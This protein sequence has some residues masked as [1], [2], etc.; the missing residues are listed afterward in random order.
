MRQSSSR[1]LLALALLLSLG[2]GALF[3]RAILTIRDDEW[4]YARTTNTNLVQALEKSVART[5]DGLDRSMVGLA[6]GIKR[7]DVMAL[8]PELRAQVLFDHSLRSPAVAAVSISD[9]HGNIVLHSSGG[10]SAQVNIAAA[11]YFAAH[12]SAAQEG[13]YIGKPQSTPLSEEFSL[14]LSRAYFDLQGDFAGVV[15]VALRLGYF[16]ELLR[17]LD[18]GANSGSNLFRADGIVLARFPYHGA[19]VG[20]SI[21]GTPTMLKLQAS[22]KGTFVGLAALDGVERLYTFRHVGVYP[23]IINVAQSTDTVL[24]HWRRSAWQLGGFALAL[25]LACMGLGGLFVRELGVRQRVSG[26]LHQAERDVRTILDNLPS[27][28]AYWDSAQ[29]NRFA[30]QAYQNLFGVTAQLLGSTPVKDLL[31]SA[32]AQSQP[33]IEGSLQGQR[34]LFERSVRDS[35]GVERFTIVSYIPDFDLDRTTPGG[36]KAVRGVFVQITDITE[37]KRMENEL[38]EEK[39]LMRLT[40]QSI[41]D[42]VLCTD[43]HASVTYINPAAERLTGWQA[44][45]AAGE[46]IDKVAPLRVTGA[47]ATE[48]SPLCQALAQVCALGPTPGVVLQRAD[49]QQFDVEESA[50]PITDRHGSVTG[51]VMVLHD[52]SESVAMA[53][54]L[55]HLAHYDALTDLPN[56]VLLK[57]RAHQALALAR[58]AGHQV[59]VLYFDLDGFKQINDT[60][61]HDVGDLL[62]VQFAQRLSAV[63]RQ[64]DTVCRQ[65]GDEFIALLPALDDPE[66]ACAVARKI[67]AICAQP[68]QVQERQ[69]QIGVSGGIALFPQHG[70]TFDELT[71]HADAAMYVAKR[72]G[73]MQFRLCAAP[74]GTHGEPQR[75]S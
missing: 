73:R 41:G 54:R 59:A 74:G 69:L 12:R 22:P 55:V 30:N 14:P 44:F 63:V 40:L 10:L 71:R 37:R 56:R 68:L 6:A 28:V 9:A 2:I 70:E 47:L 29:R 11:D 66:Q 36:A 58:R 15:V 20:R 39:E 34:Q 21:A 67:L 49:G 45:A 42:A 3:A 23:L 46:H 57:D 35:Q 43:A 19:D 50:S 33:Y 52:V 64:S 25:M 26:Q 13:L 60:L 65:G 61:G 72:S 51:A 16:N 32:Y 48:A 38:F 24:A 7:P 27:M 75:V 1:R 5:L 4:N 31:G 17:A 8:A 18:L 53:A 62:L